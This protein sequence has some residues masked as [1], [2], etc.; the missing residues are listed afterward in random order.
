ME[1]YEN[2]SQNYYE[3]ANVSDWSDC[4]NQIVSIRNICRVTLYN[5]HHVIIFSIFALFGFVGNIMLLSVILR[6]AGLQNAPNILLINITVADI[7]YMVIAAPFGIRHELF[8]C[9][10]HGSVAYKFKHYLPLVAQA[11]YIFLMAAL[12]RERYNAIVRGLESRIS[13]SIRRT[14]IVVVITWVMGFIVSIP[15]F[16]ITQTKAYGLLCQFVPM[17]NIVSQIYILAQFVLLYIIP[18][19]YIGVNHV[20]LA[21]SLCT[22]CPMQENVWRKS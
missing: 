21:R 12:S 16:W 3:T 5:L 10:L 13:R 1:D 9:W 19:A 2:Y 20:L 8:P 6:T 15:V 14:L 18:L 4:T 22:L 7:L 17:N 11:A